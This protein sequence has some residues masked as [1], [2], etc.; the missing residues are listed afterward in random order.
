MK[1]KYF[2]YAIIR[3]GSNSANQS[4]CEK[5]A[6][7][8]VNAANRGDAEKIVSEREEMG[9]YTIYNNQWIEIVLLSSLKKSE[10]EALEEDCFEAEELVKSCCILCGKPM[11]ELPVWQAMNAYCGCNESVT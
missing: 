1:K 5:A 3:H 7:D 2:D 4:M 6:I 10:R 9:K 11:G 8:I